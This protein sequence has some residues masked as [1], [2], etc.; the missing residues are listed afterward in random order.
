MN[1]K[2]VQINPFLN[3]LKRRIKIEHQHCHGK[4]LIENHLLLPLEN[5]NA[6]KSK[7]QPQNRNYSKSIGTNRIVQLS[8]WI[9]YKEEIK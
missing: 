4:R 5:K 3:G 1:N 6:Y 7:V 8:L 2:M 9:D